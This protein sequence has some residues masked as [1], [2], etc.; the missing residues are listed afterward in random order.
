MVIANNESLSGL[1]FT[2]SSASPTTSPSSGQPALTNARDNFRRSRTAARVGSLPR[3]TGAVNSHFLCFTEIIQHGAP[4]TATEE[5]PTRST[6]SE[7]GS[8][9][10]R[11]VLRER[12]RSGRQQVRGRPVACGRW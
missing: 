8:R 6:T 11:Q 1:P 7:E 10:T 2:A 3:L 9:P 4:T 5:R 12:A